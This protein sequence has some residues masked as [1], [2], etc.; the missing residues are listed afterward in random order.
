MIDM[1]I[2][3][4]CSFILSTIKKE[5]KR[6]NKKGTTQIKK[7]TDFHIKYRSETIAKNLPPFRKK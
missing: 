4:L 5:E 1:R 3:L 2:F 6:N 7:G